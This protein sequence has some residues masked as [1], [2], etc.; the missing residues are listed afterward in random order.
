MMSAFF[1]ILLK[2]EAEPAL[3]DVDAVAEFLVGARVHMLSSHV[4]QFSEFVVEEVYLIL[5]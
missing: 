5:V 4:G 1:A 3:G 2:D